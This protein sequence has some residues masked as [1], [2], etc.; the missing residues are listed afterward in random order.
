MVGKC[1]LNEEPALLIRGD[2]ASSPTERVLA[3]EVTGKVVTVEQYGKIVRLNRGL[4]RVAG[5]IWAAFPGL[6][7]F[8]KMIKNVPR[9]AAFRAMSGLQ[10]LRLYRRIANAV[11]GRRIKYR[12]ATAK[13]ALEISRLLGYWTVPELSDP[14][15]MILE[16]IES[17][18]GPSHVLIATLGER[19]VGTIVIQRFQETVTSGPD[20]WI[21]EVRIRARYQGAGI[22]RGLI[23]KALLKARQ[24]GAEG[25]GGYVSAQ[26]R[27]S[28][29]MCEN[30]HGCQMKPQ[31]Y[32]RVFAETSH[33]EPDRNIIFHRSIEELLQEL[34]VGAV[35]DR[36]RG[37]RCLDQT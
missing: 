25:L 20:W 12:T 5:L 29:A 17:A 3:V 13:D 7:R 1:S 28:V 14:V 10:S 22:A 4:L 23:I 16:K 18:N 15:G 2:E 26:N 36:Y 21:S 33:L 35:L 34:Q 31:E 32:S 24:S 19:I 9:R 27:R 37:T 11:V 8:L 30:L 6:G